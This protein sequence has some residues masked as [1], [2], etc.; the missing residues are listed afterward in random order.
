MAP[1]TPGAIQ[2]PPEVARAFVK[3]MR[4]Y[5]A[6]PDKH[7]QDAIAAKQV[8]ILGRYQ[9]PREKKLRLDDVKE[10]IAQMRDV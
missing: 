9:G 10:M 3:A 2:V 8:S 1:T 6:E 4:D 5:F 7:K